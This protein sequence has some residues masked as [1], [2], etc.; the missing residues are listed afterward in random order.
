MSKL[1]QKN[2]DNVLLNKEF[3]LAFEEI[4]KLEKKVAPDVMLKF[5]AYYKQAT[6][7][8]GSSI[9]KND[10]LKSAFKVNAWMQLEGMTIEQA[11]KE[12]I[13]LASEIL[14]KINEEND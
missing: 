13:K 14:I 11:K 9:N 1:S 12:Y 8:D 5:Y 6:L 2:K 7:G 3:A 10:D 4:S